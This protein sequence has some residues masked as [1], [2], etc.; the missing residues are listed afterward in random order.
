MAD[1]R[2]AK[3]RSTSVGEGDILSSTLDMPQAS[4]T[5]GFSNFNPD[6]CVSTPQAGRA[7]QEVIIQRTCFWMIRFQE[8]SVLVP[9]ENV[10]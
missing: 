4:S 8:I 9:G 7:L 6:R 2:V 1:M 10:R 5:N 3:R